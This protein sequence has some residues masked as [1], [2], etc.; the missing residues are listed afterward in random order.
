M[1]QATEAAGAAVQAGVVR[2]Q[3]LA[4]LQ[5]AAICRAALDVVQ[6]GEGWSISKYPAMAAAPDPPESG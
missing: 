5:A 1:F 4:R 6:G 3:A 2:Q